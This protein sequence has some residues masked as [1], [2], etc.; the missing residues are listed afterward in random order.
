MS[1]I[2]PAENPPKSTTHR[3]VAVTVALAVSA[4]ATV[5]YRFDP[6]QHRFYP[7]CPFHLL[8]GLQCP[9]CGSLRALHALTHGRVMDSLHMNALLVLTLPYLGFVAAR[10]VARALRAE[11]RREFFVSAR[12]IWAYLAV[13]VAFWILRNVPSYPFTLLAP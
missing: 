3:F 10:G 5:L 1:A 4:A 6:M 7:V 8:T 12:W 2:C 13:A 11:P 9:G